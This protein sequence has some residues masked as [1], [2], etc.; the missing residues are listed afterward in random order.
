MEIADL[1]YQCIWYDYHQALQ[2]LIDQESKNYTNF[3]GLIDDFLF[4]QISENYLCQL[5][6]DDSGYGSEF[7]RSEPD[8]VLKILK[9]ISEVNDDRVG[10]VSALCLRKPEKMEQIIT[11]ESEKFTAA[12]EADFLKEIILLT[13]LNERFIQITHPADLAASIKDNNDF[14]QKFYAF[15]G[16]VPS[17]CNPTLFLKIL[18]QHS[19]ALDFFQ[20][21]K[22][23]D[24]SIFISNSNEVSVNKPAEKPT[25]LDE[26][27]MSDNA[28]QAQKP[29]CFKDLMQKGSG[30]GLDKFH[31]NI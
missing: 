19:D 27:M 6:N 15:L 10:A 18:E 8:I 23:Y 24:M 14:Q 22:Q 12:Y 28:G 13:K 30:T 31:Q 2:Q 17:S 16:K 11:Q 7:F 5:G 4:E 21:D 9:H 25:S 20:S 26:L 3:H 29:S 1:Y